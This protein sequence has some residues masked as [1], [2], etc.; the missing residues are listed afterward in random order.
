[1]KKRILALITVAVMALSVSLFGACGSK[2]KNEPPT[3]P[4][5]GGDDPVIV[6]KDDVKF[7]EETL[8]V[9]AGET[10]HIHITGSATAYVSSNPNVATVALDGTDKLK[11]TAV[12]EG[13]TRINALDKNGERIE[14]AQCTVTVTQKLKLTMPETAETA[15][16]VPFDIP[17]TIAG[18]G[19]TYTYAVKLADGGDIPSGQIKVDRSADTV[20]VFTLTSQIENDIVFTLT[21]KK[22][23]TNEEVSASVTVKFVDFFQEKYYDASYFRFEDA[24]AGTPES[25]DV[26]PGRAQYQTALL[27]TID[28]QRANIAKLKDPD[29]QSSQA[30]AQTEEAQ[31]IE[32]AALKS[33]SAVENGYT[34]YL[35]DDVLNG[36][37]KLPANF[38]IPASYNGKPVTKIGE[39]FMHA[40]AEYRGETKALDPN[41]KWEKP[42]ASY[43]GFTVRSVFIPASVVEIGEKAFAETPLTGVVVQADGA[44][45]T[46]GK[47][48]FHRACKLSAFN[49]QN[50]TALETIGTHAFTDHNF[51]SI[52]IPKSVTIVGSGAFAQIPND[53]NRNNHQTLKSVAF[54]DDDA[55]DHAARA[56]TVYGGH[57]LLEQEGG[58]FAYN[59][60]LNSVR[61]CNIYRVQTNMF[62]QSW[63]LTDVYVDASTNGWAFSPYKYEMTGS[64]SYEYNA[65]TD[66]FPQDFTDFLTDSDGD[67]V[68]QYT[69]QAGNAVKLNKMNADEKAAAVADKTLPA[70]QEDKPAWKYPKQDGGGDYI[71]VFSGTNGYVDAQGNAY[72]DVRQQK[73]DYKA[74]VPSGGYNLLDHLMWW[75]N[76]FSFGLA[77][78]GKAALTIDNAMIADVHGLVFANMNYDS[79]GLLGFFNGT[80]SA[81]QAKCFRFATLYVKDGVEPSDFIKT[82]YAKQATSEKVG[83]VKWTLK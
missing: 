45:Q 47:Y 10:G 17:Y 12:K 1:M 78:N 8:T 18:S 63:S 21:A 3:P 69:N 34:V 2:K 14:G 42:Y 36:T 53:A 73:V 62:A 52:F 58:A 76:P 28:R 26:L 44:L 40:F 83:Y 65:D 64:E 56:V 20:P 82:K 80:T 46:I 38:V 70:E 13:K 23:A 33:A 66:I 72:A 74:N 71:P 25:F 49:F 51:T 50:C 30:S 29:A 9:E 24:Q 59:L 37:K 6:V 15:V 81:D 27:Q 16:G 79:R 43:T 31:A 55:P 57:G 54:E 67:P 77:E 60:A 41:D 75:G 11:V 39:N 19:A 35:S 4:P 22:R 61:L 68:L 32:R 5:G 48:A 7:T